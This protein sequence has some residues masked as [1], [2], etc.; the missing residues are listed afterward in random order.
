MQDGGPT[1]V[2]DRVA[3]VVAALIAD[4]DVR[5]LREKIDD[6]PLSFI[7]PLR[8]NHH[9]IHRSPPIS[10]AP[11]IRY[12]PYPCQEMA[13]NI[14]LQYAKLRAVPPASILRNVVMAQTLR[15]WLLVILAVRFFSPAPLLADEGTRFQGTEAQLQERIKA[16]AKS[17]R[18]AVCQ[19]ESVWESN[20]ELAI[21][22]RQII[23][24]R[25]IRGES[26]DTIRAYF[27]SRYGDFILLSPR[28]TGLNL[29]LWF[30]PFLL[31]LVGGLVLYFTLRRWTA[32]PA[33]APSDTP[34]IDSTT[35]ERIERELQG[36]QETR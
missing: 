14:A 15:I 27:Q 18:C 12:P 4:D 22:M 9:K 21:Q 33:L 11:D 36:F 26:P 28:P 25:L 19:S 1:I 3:G 24:D 31:L 6:L 29:L 13:P 35:R 7:A 23:R 5:R 2:D 32:S 34:P 17:L 10:A 16:V 30:G 8:S 20:A